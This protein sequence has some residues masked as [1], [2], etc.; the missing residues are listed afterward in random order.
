[1]ALGIG[2]FTGLSGALCGALVQTVTNPAYLGRVSAV[3]GLVSLGLAPLTYPV[4]GAAVA[5][6]GTGPVFVA[7]AVV[8]ATAGLYGLCS[9]PLRGAELPR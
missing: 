1:M 2:L 6:W 3:S 7:S 8:C 9:R 4:T 5:L